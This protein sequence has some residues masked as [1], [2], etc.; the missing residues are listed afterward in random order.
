MA[1]ACGGSEKQG[2]LDSSMCYDVF[3][4]EALLFVWAVVSSR[5]AWQLSTGGQSPAQQR[6][7]LI[8]Q[9]GTVAP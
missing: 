6:H 8:G 4:V 5:Y 1:A 9:A 7:T 2:G 3:V